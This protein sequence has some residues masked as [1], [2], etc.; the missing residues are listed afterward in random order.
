[1]TKFSENIEF[2]LASFPVDT[3]FWLIALLFV[4]VTYERSC[5]MIT[6]LIEGRVKV[7]PVF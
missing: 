4:L 3:N 5:N 1:M 6:E 2:K 7:L